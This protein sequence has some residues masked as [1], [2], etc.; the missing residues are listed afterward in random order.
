MFHS[1]SYHEVFIDKLLEIRSQ[2]RFPSQQNK[3]RI[4]LQQICSEKPK[5]DV[6]HALMQSKSYI[7]IL[8]FLV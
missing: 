6:P 8:W 4:K 5:P 7:V 2:L 1:S 3:K